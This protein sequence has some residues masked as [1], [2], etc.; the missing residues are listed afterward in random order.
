MSVRCGDDFAKVS[1][2]AFAILFQSKGQVINE[3]PLLVR[4][5]WF[6]HISDNILADLSEP[7]RSIAMIE[8]VS[9]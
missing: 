1:T 8:I 4:E 5:L 7:R 2:G 3:V 6:E 9:Q